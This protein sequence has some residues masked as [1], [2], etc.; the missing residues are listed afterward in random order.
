[1]PLFGLT[2]SSCRSRSFSET[3]QEM[4]LGPGDIPQFVDRVCGVGQRSDGNELSSNL[5]RVGGLVREKASEV[6]GES[7]DG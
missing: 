5:L 1:M 6:G 4:L 7:E 3:F 2:D